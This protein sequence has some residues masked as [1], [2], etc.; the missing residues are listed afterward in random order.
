M[1]QFLQV[2]SIKQSGRIPILFLL[3]MQYLYD[4]RIIDRFQLQSTGII[5]F[6]FEAF[7]RKGLVM[8]PPMEIMQQFDNYIIPI[9]KE[10]NTLATQNEILAKQRDLLLPRLM[11]GKLKVK[12]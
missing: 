7:L 8:L 4:T 2:N 10:I 9:F 1:C 11:S 12:F 5:N 3:W 6:K